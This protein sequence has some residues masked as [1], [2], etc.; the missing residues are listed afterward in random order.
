MKRRVVV[1]SKK[2]FERRSYLQKQSRKVH[3]QRVRIR[4]A[5]RVSATSKGPDDLETRYVVALT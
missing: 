4:L 2:T 1:D 5:K 3:A